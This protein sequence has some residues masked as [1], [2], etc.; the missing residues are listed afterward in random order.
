MRMLSVLLIFI[1]S[2]LPGARV[3]YADEQ[4]GVSI[5]YLA[6]ASFLSMRR[7]ASESSSTLMLTR[8]GL[9]TIFRRLCQLT[10]F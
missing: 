8:S 4:Q 3:P 1:S 5:D 7:M 9:A 2:C 6:H 10:R